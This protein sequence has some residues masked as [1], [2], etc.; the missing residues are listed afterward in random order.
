M[1]DTLRYDPTAALQY[2]S[3]DESR[4]PVAWPAIAANLEAARAAVRA[5]V[6][7][8]NS[9]GPIP[10]HMQPL[11]SGFIQWPQRLLDEQKAQGDQSLVGRIKQTAKRI[12]ENYDRVVL[13][14]IGG[15]YMG[16]KALFEALCHPYHNELSREQRSGIPR[17]YFEGNNLDN[18]A[19]R[20]LV[21]ML[22]RTAS[23]SKA[24]QD[25][26]A[27]VVISKS[28]G[29]LETAIAFRV[30]RQAAESYYGAGTDD[31]KRAIVS[32][33]GEAG[34]LRNVTN[35]QQYQDVFP[36]PD[37]IGGRFS[38]LTAVGLVPAAILGLNIEALLQGAADM[39]NSFF[40]R[41]IGQNPVMDYT[42]VSHLFEMA[43]HHIRLLSTWGK[44]LESVGF[45]YDQLLSESLGKN[46]RG[47]TPITVVNTRDLHS[48]GQQHQEGR[49]DKLVTNV[50]V[51]QHASEAVG[52]PCFQ[53]DGDDLNQ[54]A[55]KTVPDVLTAAI[56]GTNQ[57]YADD[58][59]PTADLTLPRLSEYSL[60]Q[61]LQ[62][63]M[64]ATVLEGRLLGINPYGQPGVEAYKKATM[65][66][67][68]S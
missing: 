11:D 65:R 59:R 34:K 46:G 44:K 39:T 6:E 50:I 62:M 40:Q 57:A 3:P 19:L 27:S 45:W 43:G 56:R 29:T 68:K 20:S 13:L 26:W 52:I 8:Y 21:E 25:R 55:S 23:A 38:I 66:L 61:F 18:D 36:I 67:L 54:Y 14:G 49:R 17:V 64:L 12:Q 35:Q 53:P 9:A 37:G 48:R 47:A 7:L 51:A 1:A 41:P 63:M 33:T 5:E 2:L 28:G 16:A 4:T 42:G 31:L 60:G 10:A 24:V 22:P 58:R 32:I 30:F 15:S